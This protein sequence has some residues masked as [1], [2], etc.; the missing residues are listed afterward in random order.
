MFVFQAW[1]FISKEM[2]KVKAIGKPYVK[3]QS[4]KTMSRMMDKSD[5]KVPEPW[6]CDLLFIIAIDYNLAVMIQT[7]LKF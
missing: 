1:P 6:V 7:Q 4:H 2:F 3:K 5:C